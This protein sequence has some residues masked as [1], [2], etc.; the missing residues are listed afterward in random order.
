[1]KNLSKKLLYD[2]YIVKRKSMRKIGKKLDWSY[3]G[4]RKRLIKYGISLRT[5]SESLMGHKIPKWVRRKIAKSHIGMKASLETR[6]KLSKRR[7]GI[8][9]PKFGNPGAKNPNWCGG[10][11]K[12]PYSFDFTKEL[13]QEIRERDKY[14]CQLC[15]CTEEEHL[16]IYG[17]VLLIHHIDYDKK[18]CEK[19]NL[20]SLCRQCNSRVNFNRE[21]W[22][23]YFINLL[24]KEKVWKKED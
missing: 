3:G 11:S 16:V 23:K 13:K 1:M 24:S 17:I 18:N 19:N 21:Y 7:K 8:K 5:A 4:I 2:E 14:T 20:I 6:I 12:L 9:N 15:G 22:K 10:I